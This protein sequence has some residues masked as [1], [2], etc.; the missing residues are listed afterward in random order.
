ML[1]LEIRHELA[2]RLASSRRYWGG[3]RSRHRCWCWCE[4]WYEILSLLLRGLGPAR[5]LAIRDV[6]VGSWSLRLPRR[7]RW[8]RSY[9]R[10]SSRHLWSRFRLGEIHSWNR[11]RHRRRRGRGSLD[12]LLRLLVLLLLLSGF[13]FA[14]WMSD[15]RSWNLSRSWGGRSRWC[16]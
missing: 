6:P 7:L 2:I 4:R 15:G 14:V 12:R 5:R 11:R 10:S 3:S 1:L 13:E 8:R 16:S 9:G